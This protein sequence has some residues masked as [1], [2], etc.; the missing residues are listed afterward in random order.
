MRTPHPPYDPELEAAL[1]VFHATGFRTSTSRENLPTYR[2]LFDDIQLET[3]AFAGVE[4]EEHLIPGP[5]GGLEV[6]ITVMRPAASHRLQPI[7]RMLHL[8]GGGMI[9]GNRHVGLD[10]VAE[11]ME[12][13]PIMVV[14]VEY[15]L[16]PENPYPTGA[17]DCYASLLW[18]AGH[19]AELGIDTSR[20]LVAGTSAGGGLAAAVAL[21]A[22]DR[23]G[24]HVAAQ[25]LACPMLDDRM[26]TPSSTEYENE[27]TWDRFSNATGWSCLLGS[28][29]GRS[30]TAAYAAPAWP[31]P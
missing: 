11:W 16:A 18:M 27:G 20:L 23:R 19:P 1:G 15:R 2:A 4:I 25:L 12:A 13:V 28:S 10:Q 14:S 3:E 7:P 21:M 8:H 9:S 5:E 22:R 30:D 24:P 29:V 26:I 6:Q 17:E 31:T